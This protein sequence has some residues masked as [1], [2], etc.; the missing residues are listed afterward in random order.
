MPGK[1]PE[2]L[3]GGGRIRGW[4]DLERPVCEKSPG[5]ERQNKGRVEARKKKKKGSSGGGLKAQERPATE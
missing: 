1:N 3:R 2:G 5:N 4:G